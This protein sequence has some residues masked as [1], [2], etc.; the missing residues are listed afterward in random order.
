MVVKFSN[1]TNYRDRQ[2][3]SASS[4]MAGYGWIYGRRPQREY[5]DTA[6]VFDTLRAGDRPRPGTANS[7]AKD[8]EA[9]TR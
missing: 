3:S 9:L 7:I 1:L 6:H 4:Y 2:S 8:K 5:N